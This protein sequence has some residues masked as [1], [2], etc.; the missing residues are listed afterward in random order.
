MKLLV[1]IGLLSMAVVAHA[2]CDDLAKKAQNEQSEN[3]RRQAVV[4]NLKKQQDQAIAAHNMVKAGRLGMEMDQP[5]L[6]PESDAQRR[7]TDCQN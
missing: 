6:K 7:L 2:A 4:A 5:A 1:L 3:S